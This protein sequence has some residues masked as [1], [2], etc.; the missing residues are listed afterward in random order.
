MAVDVASA[1]LVRESPAT[2]GGKADGK[3]G[4]PWR[5]VYDVDY[6]M[7]FDI[8]EKIGLGKKDYNLIKL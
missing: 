1:D 5:A 2:P 3:G 7:L 4:D 8:G 6:R